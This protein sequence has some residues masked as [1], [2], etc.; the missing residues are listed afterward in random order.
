MIG[1]FCPRIKSKQ[2]AYFGVVNEPYNHH[3]TTIIP[4]K[5]DNSGGLL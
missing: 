1:I 4:R 2:E 5:I 3:P